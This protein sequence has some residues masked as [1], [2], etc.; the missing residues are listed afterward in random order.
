[1]DHR[2]KRPDSRKISKLMKRITPVVGILN[3]AMIRVPLVGE[4]LVVGA[5][6]SL[7]RLTARNRA[8]GFRTEPGYENA[9]YNWELY[10]ELLGADYQ[11]KDA[12]P[13][14][15]IY[16]FIRCPAGFTEPEHL[17]ACAAT[18]ELDQALVETSGARLIIEKRIPEDG[19]CSVRLVPA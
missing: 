15:K 1:M 5:G 8:L 4:K 6:K 17:A 14:D 13:T 12:G 9:L 3:R 11:K 18:M 7:G 10:L 19:M 2:P 16:T